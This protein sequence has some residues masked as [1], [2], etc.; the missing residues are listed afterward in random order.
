MGV[1]ENET[2]KNRT[3]DSKLSPEMS[4]FSAIFLQKAPKL[5]KTAF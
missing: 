1:K 2:A 3:F 4:Y 5:E